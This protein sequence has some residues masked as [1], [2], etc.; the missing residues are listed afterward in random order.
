MLDELAAT[1]QQI[2]LNDREVQHLAPLPLMEVTTD[3]RG[4]FQLGSFPLLLEI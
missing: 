1:L 2:A 4:Q 3:S